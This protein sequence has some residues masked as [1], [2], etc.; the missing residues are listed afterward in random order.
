MQAD[1]FIA[2]SRHD[3]AVAESIEQ[4]FVASG[5]R[6]YRDLKNIPG[7][8]DWVEEIIEA[9]EACYAVLILASEHSVGSEH[10]YHELTIAAEARK[11]FIPV[12]LSPNL[13]LPK[14]WSY[15]LA[16]HQQIVVTSTL[17]V[18]LPDIVAASRLAVD[19]TRHR[20]AY[21]HSREIE[22]GEAT[23]FRSEVSFASE[24]FGLFLGASNSGQASIENDAY[25][26]AAAPGEWFGSR[27]S[28]LPKFTD[29]R[30][31][32]QMKR[33]NGPDTEWFGVE[34]GDA[35]PGNYFQVVYNDQS[36][37]RVARHLNGQ[38]Q[39]LAIHHHV[40]QAHP[41]GAENVIRIVR[42][43]D[44][45]HVFLNGLH[46]LSVR[47]GNIRIGGFGFVVGPGLRVAFGRI[48]IAGSAANSLFKKALEHWNR[49]EI[50]EA[51][52]I[53]EQLRECDP[54]LR[55]SDCP[56]TVSQLLREPRPDC[57]STV[58]LVVGSSALAQLYDGA[59]AARLRE[60]INRHGVRT[61]YQFSSVVT[62]DALMVE[63]V[64]L[65]CPTISIGGPETNK[66]TAK[67]CE[68]LSTDPLSTTHVRIQHGLT[69]KDRRVALWGSAAAE[70]SDAVD[71]FV[72][73]GLLA[74]YLGLL[75]QERISI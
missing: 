13:K 19:R 21:E 52:L 55:H 5:L 64:F 42:K 17:A 66:L 18:A 30:W 3:L 61:K 9:V 48:H 25:V 69:T 60:E 33:I 51:A 71:L 75:W 39:D 11:P 20:E 63:P 27:A 37:L 12:M 24:R 46:A 4:E 29:A 14:K 62:D 45:L 72:K 68:Q 74:K 43:R 47:D 67:L 31:D 57:R 73:S 23:N 56:V 40:P 50:T 59:A 54:Q 6:S 16:S 1:V 10:V 28:D 34:F 26:L 65:R 8:T 70:T 44:C 58:L 7:S 38:W 2:Y 35:Y 53:L 15:H 32:V 49:L 41:S 36:T 22:D